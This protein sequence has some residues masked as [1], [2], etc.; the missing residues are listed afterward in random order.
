MNVSHLESIYRPA[1]IILLRHAEKP[2]EGIILSEQGYRRAKLLPLFFKQ[3]PL[4]ST[5][6]PPVAIFAAAPKKPGLSIR[7][8]QTMIPLAN[9]FNLNINENFTKNDIHQLV[10]T[11]FSTPAYHGKMII[12]CWDRSGIPVIAKLLGVNSS[13]LMWSKETFDRCWIINYAEK[14]FPAF[15]DIAQNFF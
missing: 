9:V 7:S 4:L 10:G 12:I 3:H 13:P 11:I 8:I 6:G 14:K 2:N 1:Q 15:L 5:F